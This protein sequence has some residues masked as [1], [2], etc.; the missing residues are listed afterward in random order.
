M[1][2]KIVRGVSNKSIKFLWFM[3]FLCYKYEKFYTEKSF[4]IKDI[5]VR[6]QT[7]INSTTGNKGEI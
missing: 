6:K 5:Y 7:T 2:S 1:Y 3:I 4:Q